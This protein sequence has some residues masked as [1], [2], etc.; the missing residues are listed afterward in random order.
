MV[1]QI[2]NTSLWTLNICVSPVYVI[3]M[4]E[5]NVSFS[6]HTAHSIR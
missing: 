2:P 5:Q 4:C 3:L 1:F 6:C